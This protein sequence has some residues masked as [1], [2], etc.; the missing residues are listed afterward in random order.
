MDDEAVFDDAAG[1]RPAVVDTC[2]HQLFYGNPGTDKKTF[3]RVYAQTLCDI[4]VV[5]Q[6]EVIEVT[7]AQLKGSAVGMAENLVAEVFERAQGKVL[8]ISEAYNLLDD[9]PYSAAMIDTLVSMVQPNPL[10]SPVII[11]AGCQDRMEEMF[12]K[13]NPGLKRRLAVNP[14]F[15]F[16]DFSQG[17]H[18]LVSEAELSVLLRNF[19]RDHTGMASKAQ[20]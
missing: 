3:A 19:L 13:A 14:P 20:Q 11:M 5:E 18:S 15:M 4:G 9:S 10:F 1:S 6:G 17:G 16:D 7:P 12:L 8:F 2:F